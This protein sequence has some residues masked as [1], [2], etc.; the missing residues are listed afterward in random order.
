MHDYTLTTILRN[1]KRNSR[2]LYMHRKKTVILKY[3]T[4]KSQRKQTRSTQKNHFAE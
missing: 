1:L 4:D 2:Y 3:Q